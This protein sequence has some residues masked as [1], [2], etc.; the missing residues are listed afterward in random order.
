MIKQKQYISALI[1]F[2][3]IVPFSLHSRSD[4]IEATLLNDS[5]IGYYQ[6]TTCKI[7]L[8]EF[9]FANRK[10]SENIYFNNNDYA[11][12]NC[13]GKITGVDKVNDT[14]SVSIGTNTSFSILIQ[15]LIWILILSLI[16]KVNEKSYLTYKSLYILPFLLT[17][18]QLSENRFYSRNNILYNSEISTENLYLLGILLLNFFITFLII[19]SLNGR[20]KNLTN[21][22]PF[23]FLFVGTYLGSNLNFY[24]IFFSCIGISFYFKEKKLLKSDKYYIVFLVFWIL[25]IKNNNYF[26]DGDKLRGFSNSIYSFRSQLFW[27]IIIFLTV[28]GFSYLVEKSKEEF[29]INKFM[30]N[31][32]ISGGFTVIFGLV[33]AV[34]PIINFFNFFLFGQNKRGMK[35]ITSIAGNTWRGFSSS[36]ESIGEVYGFIL[37]VFFVLIMS[38]KIKISSKNVTLSLLIIFGLLRSN[39]FA[40]ML[41]LFLLIIIYTYFKFYKG[42]NKR[43]HI[44]LFIVFMILGLI[45]LFFNSNYQFNTS[46]LIYEATRHQSFYENI[47]SSANQLGSSSKS[48]YL[49][50]E[51][52]EKNDVGTILLTST[53]FGS[54]SLR[55]LAISLNRLNLFELST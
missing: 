7:S 19:E 50:L 37:L 27:I 43:L 4:D 18:Q 22:L 46:N 42:N 26:F 55:V 16:P 8:F 21:Y 30:N 1:L 47:P 6:S 13:F 2:I 25:N 11:D 36:A 23:L 32:F 51:A 24:L 15:S 41:S 49:V 12:I 10:I 9:Y 29:K 3:L 28:R 35:E 20:F 44:F 5:T 31:L 33:G 34:S 38:K 52:I 17:Y 53:T 54:P 40:S 48:H 39:N 45:V 14:Y